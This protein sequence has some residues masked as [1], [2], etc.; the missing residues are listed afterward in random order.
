MEPLETLSAISLLGVALAVIG[1]FTGSL[2][3]TTTGLVT[4]V[5]ALTVAFFV[6][7]FRLARATATWSRTTDH[8][9]DPFLK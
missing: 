9:A 8:M 2:L 7:T 1:E 5:L 6:M 4:F 3:T